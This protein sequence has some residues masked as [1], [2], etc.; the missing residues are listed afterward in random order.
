MIIN[1]TVSYLIK[2]NIQED[3]LAVLGVFAK[4]IYNII[5]VISA[6]FVATITNPMV[7]DGSVPFS[8]SPIQHSIMELM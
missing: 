6:F 4:V 5:F 7:L 2:H 3:G 1:I 8:A